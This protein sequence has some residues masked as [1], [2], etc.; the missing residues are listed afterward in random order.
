VTEDLSKIKVSPIP[1]RT[2]Q[3][4]RNHLFDI[5][6]PRGQP[7]DPAY[8]L[9]VELDEEISSLA[10]ERTGLPTRANLRVNAKFTLFDADTT[11]PSSLFT[12]WA[13]VISSYNLLNSDFSTLTSQNDARSRA[14]ES[15]ADQIRT[16]L[17]AFFA[18]RDAAAAKGG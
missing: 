17:A 14:M 1:D 11:Q 18:S 13:Q 5:L 16:R 4:L 2:G 15:I 12:G 7:R 9:S 3:E 6:T 10:V 8:I